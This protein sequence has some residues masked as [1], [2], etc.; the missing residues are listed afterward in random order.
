MLWFV[1]CL[2][3]AWPNSDST[4]LNLYGFSK[5]VPA[6]WAG[7]KQASRWCAGL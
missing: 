7:F 5:Y 1:L 3:P 6:V 2:L 4:K